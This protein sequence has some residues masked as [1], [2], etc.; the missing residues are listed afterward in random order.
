[1]LGNLLQVVWRSVQQRY[2]DVRLLERT[3]VVGAVAGHERDEAERLE[4][5]EDKLFLR[6]RD[7]GIDPDVL[8][9]RLPGGLVGELLQ[10][11]A[12]DADVVIIEQ[13]GVQW[14]RWVDRDDLA[15]VD[16]VPNKI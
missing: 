16:R 2:T 15:V 13:G 12:G 10:R 11:R 9:E 5:R 3:D 1:M 14:F 8:D 6:G 4:R 7:A